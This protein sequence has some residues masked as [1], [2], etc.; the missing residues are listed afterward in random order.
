MTIDGRGYSICSFRKPFL[1]DDFN[2]F[3]FS[4]PAAVPVWHSGHAFDPRHFGTLA[5][6]VWLHH[7][8]FHELLL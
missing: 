2:P 6:V 1:V 7:I 3:F 4:F 5:V 8:A